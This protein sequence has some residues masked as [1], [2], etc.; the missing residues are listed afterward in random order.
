MSWTVITWYYQ[1]CLHKSSQHILQIGIDCESLETMRKNIHMAKNLILTAFDHS[2][3]DHTFCS[4]LLSWQHNQW[5]YRGV[6]W[7]LFEAVQWWSTKPGS[8][9][10]FCINS[11]S[12]AF[13]RSTRRPGW[14]WL[15]LCQ[16]NLQLAVFASAKRAL[17]G[18]GGRP[19]RGHDNPWQTWKTGPKH[20]HQV[21]LESVAGE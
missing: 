9:E 5:K 2:A 3:H 12:K 17:W 14:C 11:F 7:D 16:L 20:Q 18:Q 6:S 10:E 1:H 4:L 15:I 13:K 21:V 19:V 8:K